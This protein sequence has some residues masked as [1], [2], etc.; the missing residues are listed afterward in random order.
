MI[1]RD[2]RGSLKV[3]F[4]LPPVVQGGPLLS[5]RFL[6]SE[7]L[8]IDHFLEHFFDHFSTL[9]V[10]IHDFSHFRHFSVFSGVIGPEGGETGRAS[11]GSEVENLGKTEEISGVPEVS[12]SVSKSVKK[13][14]QAR[15]CRGS[16]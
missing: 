8:K 5:R 11:S 13:W 15:S 14:S 6:R 12:Q 1:F 4:S 9:F 2:F 7:N 3:H 16:G 10:K